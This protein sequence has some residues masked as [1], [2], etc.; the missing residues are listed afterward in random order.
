[1]VFNLFVIYKCK[2]MSLRQLFSGFTNVN[3]LPYSWIFRQFFVYPIIRMGIFPDLCFTLY[4]MLK[5]NQTYGV[6]NLPYV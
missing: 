2:I 1:M 4:I 6:D 5:N 3:T